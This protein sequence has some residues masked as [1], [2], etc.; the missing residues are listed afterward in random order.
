[1]NGPTSGRRPAQST[2][3]G[4]GLHDPHLEQVTAALPPMSIVRPSS[5]SNTRTGWC[6]RARCLPPVVVHA[7]RARTHLRG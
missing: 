3:A 4:K 6:G 1:M 5:R 7:M 2:G